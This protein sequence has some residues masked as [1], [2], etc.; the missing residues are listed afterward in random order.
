[1]RSRGDTQDHVLAVIT[2]IPSTSFEVSCEIDYLNVRQASA[3]LHNLV[4]AGLAEVVDTVVQAENGKKAKVFA[5]KKKEK[6]KEFNWRA[7][8]GLED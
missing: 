2:E 6:P 1:M 4:K 8:V 3:V 5:A 7:S